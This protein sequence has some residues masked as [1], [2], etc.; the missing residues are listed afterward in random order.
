MLKPHPWG[1]WGL[2]R[3]Q[4]RVSLDV[5]NGT[6]RL[7]HRPSLPSFL[8]P[9]WVDTPCSHSGSHLPPFPR[10]AL[11]HSPPSFYPSFPL[12]GQGG[13]EN[14]SDPGIPPVGLVQ[15]AQRAA[16]EAYPG[17]LPAAMQSAAPMKPAIV[18]M[19]AQEP[20][21]L[22]PCPF[23]FYLFYLFFLLPNLFFPFFFLPFLPTFVRQ[24]RSDAPPGLYATHGYGQQAHAHGW[25]AQGH[26][27]VP[28][29]E[30][31][32]YFF[33]LRFFMILPEV[34]VFRCSTRP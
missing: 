27:F 13:G 7:L 16:A 9:T 23:L 21:Q 15:S 17:L 22:S 31:C 30:F 14:L 20:S 28:S 32:T 2:G 33:L 3:E 11:V 26:M 19:H 1:G 5:R 29:T 24:P 18:S 8:P 4:K 34:E 6:I 12:L 25:H 10:T